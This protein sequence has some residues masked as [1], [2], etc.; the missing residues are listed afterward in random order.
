MEDVGIFYEHKVFFTAI[1]NIGIFYRHLV[2]FIEIWYILVC[3]TK[4][5]LA[6]LSCTSE[7]Q[8]SCDVIREVSRV[9]FSGN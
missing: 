3:C 8:T 1:W 4:K 2:Y 7:K 5:Y 6:T 9:F